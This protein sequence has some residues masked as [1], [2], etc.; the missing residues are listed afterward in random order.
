MKNEKQNANMKKV[1]LDF[2]GWSGDFNPKALAKEGITV[3]N[4]VE[5][6][7]AGGNPNADFFG[8]AT[9]LENMIGD[10]FDEDEEHCEFLKGLI[11]SPCGCRSGCSCASGFDN[12]AQ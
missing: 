6:G 9:A 4:F 12:G 5:E 3:K 8:T 11:S 7:P 10:F 1:N 2:I